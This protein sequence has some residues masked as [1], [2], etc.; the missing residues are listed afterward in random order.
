MRFRAYSKASR[1]FQ[2]IWEEI[3]GEKSWKANPWVWVVK[4]RTLSKTGRPSDELIMKNWKEVS[5]V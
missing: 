2:C 5:H 1:A 3:N 4:F